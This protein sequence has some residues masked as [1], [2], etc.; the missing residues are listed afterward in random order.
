MIDLLL[1][2][3][4]KVLGRNLVEFFEKHRRSRKAA[5]NPTVLVRCHSY[6]TDAWA[7]FEDAVGTAFS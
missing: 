3:N 1:R 5:T 4:T 7:E 6:T 2:V